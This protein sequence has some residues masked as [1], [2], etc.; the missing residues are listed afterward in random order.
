MLNA[1]FKF[2]FLALIAISLNHCGKKVSRVETDSTID[3]SGKWNDADSRMVAEAMVEDCLSK[4]W[5]YPFQQNKQNPRVIIGQ[6]RNKSHEH[7]SVETFVRDMERA[8]LN[9]GK[10][11]FVAGKIE[12]QQLRGE[13]NDMQ[14][15]ASAQTAKSRGEELGAQLMLIGTLNAITDKEGKNS[16]VFYQVNME[17]IELESNSKKWTGEKK[18]KKYIQ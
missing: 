6:I 2:F 11:D 12:R 13:V 17:L 9:S 10:V 5:L 7:I 15:N 14:S 16:V 1:I 3:L 4:P 8:L 18:I